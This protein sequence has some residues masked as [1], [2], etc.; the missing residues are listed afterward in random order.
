M[1][2]KEW[3]KTQIV[4]ARKSNPNVT[5][6]AVEHIQELFNSQLTEQQLTSAELKNISITLLQDMGLHSPETSG[7]Q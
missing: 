6:T 7:K 3:I 1:L 2:N 5:D 4:E